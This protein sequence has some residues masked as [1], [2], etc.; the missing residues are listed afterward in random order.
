M[1]QRARV[2]IVL[3]IVA[4]IASVI[5]LL[6]WLVAVLQ[7][8][9]F[10]E[11][12][13][14]LAESAVGVVWAVVNL[15]IAVYAAFRLTR[16]AGAPGAPTRQVT[17]IDESMY[18][19]VRDGGTVIQIRTANTAVAILAV[20]GLIV[21][22]IWS[23]SQRP[24]I[25]T[26]SMPAPTSALA[27]V[28]PTDTSVPPTNTPVLLTDTP[29]VPTDT[30]VL[31]TDTPVPPTDMSVRPTDTSVPPT[32]TPSRTKAVTS[33]P[34]PIAPTPSLLP[35]P[36]LLAPEDEAKF[37]GWNAEVLFRWSDIGHLLAENE[38]YVLIIYHKK[39]A[40]FTWTK[41]TWYDASH[42]STD[43]RGGKQ[44]LS[45]PDIGPDLKWQVVVAR[46][47]AGNPNFGDN[48]ANPTGTERSQYSET[49]VFHWYPET[50]G[51]PTVVTVPPVVT[52]PSP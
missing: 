43:V 34:R 46:S 27:P 16:E 42:D 25:I 23:I 14:E 12:M 49:H 10:P 11:P 22:L 4:L 2:D 48:G 15:S 18:A 28:L 7:P 6:I 36:T 52:I 40:D 20:I 47:S 38:Y 9:S 30:R 39:G 26:P 41:N 21:A 5:N 51:P 35:A 1:E 3:A 8:T 50:S 29:V 45:D 31:P 33:T 13:A 44:W 32:P 37:S 24:I 17:T 19:H